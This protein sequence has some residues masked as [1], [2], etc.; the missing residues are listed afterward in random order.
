MY[1]KDLLIEVMEI[2]NIISN[3]S[4]YFEVKLFSLKT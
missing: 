1:R 3:A 2:R 4:I